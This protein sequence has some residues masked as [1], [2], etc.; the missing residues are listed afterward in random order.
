MP[1]SAGGATERGG[2]APCESH[3]GRARAPGV[4]INRSNGEGAITG[5]MT[6]SV[7]NWVKGFNNM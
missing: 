5:I 3:G 7:S 1:V 6:G 4:W 2:G